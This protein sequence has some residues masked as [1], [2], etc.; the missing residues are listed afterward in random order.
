MVSNSGFRVSWVVPE[1]HLDFAPCQGTVTALNTQ[2][3]GV[4]PKRSFKFTSCK[5]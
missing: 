2:D 5:F 4:V 1:W 3:W